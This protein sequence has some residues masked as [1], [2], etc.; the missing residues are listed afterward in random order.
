MRLLLKYG[1]NY[2]ILDDEPHEP[3]DEHRDVS[4]GNDDFDGGDGGGDDDED[5]QV[6]DQDGG[7]DSEEEGDYDGRIESFRWHYGRDYKR[8]VEV[9]HYDSDACSYYHHYDR[10]YH[11]TGYDEDEESTSVGD[12]D[13]NYFDPLVGPIGSLGCL[14]SRR[15]HAYQYWFDMSCRTLH[16]HPS[17][18]L[19]RRPCLWSSQPPV[20]RSRW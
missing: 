8:Y 7:G 16:P 14:C 17:Q 6:D 9:D 13:G 11:V 2:F 19:P 4:D 3:Y 18:P 15:H 1:A 10:R 12:S 5:R 20:A